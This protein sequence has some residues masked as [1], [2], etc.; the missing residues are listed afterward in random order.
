MAND[1][2]KTTKI[3]LAV[4]LLVVAGLVAAY[5]QGVFDSA[6][7][8]KNDPKQ[9]EINQQWEKQQQ[10]MKNSPRPTAPAGAN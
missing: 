10:E 8:P 5:T 9:Q 2:K 4:A 7:S 1:P 3:I 6:P